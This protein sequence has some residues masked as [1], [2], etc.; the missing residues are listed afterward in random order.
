MKTN[1]QSGNAFLS[2]VQAVH[3]DYK[4]LQ[5]RCGWVISTRI[6]TRCYATKSVAKDVAKYTGTINLPKTKFPARLNAEKRNQLEEQLRKD[7]FSKLY[8]WNRTNLPEENEF[9]LHDGPPYA[10][11]DLH[12]GHAVNKLLKDLILKHKI[13][14]GTRVHYVPGWDCHG[15]PIELKALE[16]FHKK[17]KHGSTE[18]SQTALHIRNTAR[19]FAV[20][21]ITKQKNAF[22]SWG[23]T[24][25]W[26]DT[27]KGYYRT[28]DPTYIRAQLRLFH[29]LYERNLIYRDLKPVYWSPS[30]QSALAEAELEYDEAHQSPSLYLK[31]SLSNQAA[32]CPAIEQQ[33]HAGTEVFAV[34]WTTTPWTLPANQA[35]CYNPS[36]E[37][38]L[39][40]S[41]AGDMLLI[42]KDLIDYLSQQLALCLE[43]LQIIPAAQ[44]Q[45]LKYHHPFNRA[46]LLPF[47]PGAHV[48]AEKGTGLVHTAPA[49]GPEDFLVCLEQKIAVKN[50]IDEKGC[51]NNSA[52]GFL[53]GKYALTDGNQLITE[54]LKH[55]TLKLTTMEHSYPIDWR[56]KQPVMLRASDQ[57]FIDTNSLKHSAL[58]AIKEV[59]IYP[60][61]SSDVSK[62]VLEGQLRKRPYWCIS[63]QRAWGVPIPALYNSTSKQPI[64]HPLLLAAVEDRLM[65]ESSIDFW[66]TATLEDLVPK[67]M[68][69]ELNTTCENLEKGH[70][71]MDI[72]FDSGASWM[73]VL[74]ND[75]VAD[76]YLEGIDQFTGWF[77]SSLLTSIAARGKAP[78][79]AI[80]V[81]GFAVDE[82]GLKMSKSLG[83]V[84][85]PKSIVDRYGCDTLRWWVCAHAIQ[86]TSI[87]VS[88][89]LL[90]S[91]AESVQ[92]LRG[93]LKFLLGVLTTNG[94]CE[95]VPTVRDD[96]LRHVDRY[97]LRQQAEFHRTVF[98]LYESYQ[99]NRAS[100]TIL[101]FCLS[102]LSGL[103][104]HVVK[105]RLYCGTKAEQDNVTAIL[106]HTYRVLSKALWPI[107]PYLVE[108]SWTFYAKDHFFKSPQPPSPTNPLE[109]CPST[110]AIE[111]GLELRHAVYQQAQLNVNT[112]LL[113]LEVF[114]TATDLSSL[115][116]LHPLRDRAESTS[117]LCE[118]LQ[119]GS[120]VLREGHADSNRFTI[121]VS[122][123]D[124]L[125]CRRCRRY[126]LP[127]ENAPPSDI[128]P[129][130]ETVLKLQY[131]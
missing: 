95:T 97:Y 98:Q 101:N 33:Q 39:V 55:A 94:P 126:L 26:N 17:K 87:P 76:L 40:R 77:Q 115:S 72:W 7:C 70:D 68:L 29:E 14:S 67:Q 11:G 105:D 99:H 10:N 35:I 8:D 108:E 119:V 56:T 71:I 120:I 63:R 121:T 124:K 45:T 107:V 127:F 43:V 13:I 48:K 37:Y 110:A 59:D 116:L 42:G 84:I 64:V 20:E 131:S 103:Y 4:M 122:K 125:L 41:S 100:A 65:K 21:T 91:S 31:L 89:K 16:A 117:E 86:N 46:E 15:L 73:T 47:L 113:D 2:S 114:C 44:L 60:R 78:Y 130:C 111:S 61:T 96:Q 62:K 74:G 23:V 90:G 57:W 32:G 58:E 9:V 93:I 85:S 54:M 1:L 12:M 109:P 79:K 82:N 69:R 129:R 51:Y 19:K 49:H 112:W 18:G 6:T 102:T 53:V 52:P 123:S 30:S 128:C 83:N 80:F 27:T 22:E 3:T 66:W 75:R 81:H 38:S 36:L 106:D 28:L 92:K 118:L 50:L 34:I 88:H 25:A 104:V 24:G 5:S